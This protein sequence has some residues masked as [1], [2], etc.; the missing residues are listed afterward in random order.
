MQW[1]ISAIFIAYWSE[2]N[3]IIQWFVRRK[4]ETLWW[5]LSEWNLSWHCASCLVQYS[6]KQGQ[7]FIS[8]TID[9]N[10]LHE[11]QHMNHDQVNWIKW[12]RFHQNLLWLIAA[13][14]VSLLKWGHRLSRLTG[15]GNVFDKKESLHGSNTSTLVSTNTERTVSAAC[16][17]TKSVNIVAA[18]ENLMTI[19]DIDDS[20]LSLRLW[21]VA[22]S[23]V[24]N[25][26]PRWLFINRMVCVL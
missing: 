20:D 23:C 12:S 5:T 26:D 7:L 15:F 18:D 8:R 24:E 14:L 22:V 25:G 4:K 17:V 11:R 3:H 10:V 19:R 13:L 9:S 16:H 21:H 1:L 6:H 2:S